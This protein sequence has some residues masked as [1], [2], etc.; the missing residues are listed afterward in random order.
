[1][2]TG[3]S[4]F[5]SLLCHQVWNSALR[6]KYFRFWLVNYFFILRDNYGFKQYVKVTEILHVTCHKTDL[7]LCCG[8]TFGQTLFFFPDPYVSWYRYCL[9]LVTNDLPV[10]IVSLW[11]LC[12]TS[13]MFSAV[14]KFYKNVCV[15]WP[16]LS[17]EAIITYSWLTCGS[18]PAIVPTVGRLVLPAHV[19]LTY[20][21][22]KFMC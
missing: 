7:R 2:A 4:L 13:V 14:N 22:P 17:S 1:M 9:A 6:S 15:H 18:H 8:P 16:M 3:M 5:C 11:F 20:I 21:P 12:L 19:E 10:N